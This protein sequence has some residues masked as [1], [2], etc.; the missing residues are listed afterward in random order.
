MQTGP[1]K[2]AQHTHAGVF[3]KGDDA[4]YCYAP[5][6]QAVMERDDL[7][8]SVQRALQELRDVLRACEGR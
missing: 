3:I 4:L 5:A 6:V 2:P 1:F 7:P 8:A